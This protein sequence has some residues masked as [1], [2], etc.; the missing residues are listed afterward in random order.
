LLESSS[1]EFKEPFDEELSFIKATG[2]PNLAD[3]DIKQEEMQRRKTRRLCAAKM[4]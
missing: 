1:L 3:S 2:T 4:R